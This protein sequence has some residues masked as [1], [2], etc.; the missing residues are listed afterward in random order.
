MNRNPL[1][2]CIKFE[3]PRMWFLYFALNA[4]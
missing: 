1:F 3:V 2:L 4:L